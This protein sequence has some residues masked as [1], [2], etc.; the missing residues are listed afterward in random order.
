MRLSFGARIGERS[1]GACEGPTSGSSRKGCF[2]RC[3]N[4]GLKLRIIIATLLLLSQR[5]TSDE[6]ASLALLG[7]AV[8]VWIPSHINVSLVH[9]GFHSIPSCEVRSLLAVLIAAIAE[10]LSRTDEFPFGYEDLSVLFRSIDGQD[11]SEEDPVC[12]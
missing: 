10:W 3:A 4:S 12:A 1:V 2:S 6:D 11:Q 8:L 7:Q 5:S 9:Q